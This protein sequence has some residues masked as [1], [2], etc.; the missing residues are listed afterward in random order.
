MIYHISLPLKQ[1]E[2]SWGDGLSGRLTQGTL[3][4][5]SWHPSPDVEGPQLGWD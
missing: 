3:L 1:F 2:Q 4:A 5:A